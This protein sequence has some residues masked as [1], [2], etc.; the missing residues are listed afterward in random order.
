MEEKKSEITYEEFQKVASDYGE[1]SGQDLLTDPAT[2]EK[3]RERA[4]GERSLTHGEMLRTVREKRGFSLEELAVRTGIDR[5]ILSQ[6]EAGDYMPSLG[7]LIRLSKALSLRMSDVIGP[8]DESF[9]IVK[10]NQRQSFSRFGKARESCYGYEYESLAPRKKNRGMEPFIVTLQP[11]EANE[12]SSH[13]GQEFIYVLEGEM[14]VMIEGTREV[15]GPGD[16][17]YYDSTS[18]HLLKAHGGKPAKILAV[19]I[20]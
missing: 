13:D 2:L 3:V 7:Q 1:V 12:P 9:T 16:S 18:L 8:G 20:S 11:S 5:S 4:E 14:E 10:S 6:I 17:V 19:L 15:L